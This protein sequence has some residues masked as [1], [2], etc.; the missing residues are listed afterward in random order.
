MNKKIKQIAVFLGMLAL[1]LTPVSYTHLDVYKRQV[2]MLMAAIAASPKA[3]AAT[4][5]LIVARLAVPCLNT[6]SYTHLYPATGPLG[7]RKDP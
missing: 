6:V 3:P 1:G 4:L 2:T 5:R 7:R